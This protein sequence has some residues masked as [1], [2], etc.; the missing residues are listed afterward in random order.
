ME[1]VLNCAFGRDGA[2]MTF[3][4]GHRASIVGDTRRCPPSV[5]FEAAAS[6]AN[7]CHLPIFMSL[8]WR[9]PDFCQSRWH[10][11]V[12]RTSEVEVTYVQDTGNP[13]AT[14]I[15]AVDPRQVVQGRPTCPVRSPRSRSDTHTLGGWRAG[16][17][18]IRLS[19]NCSMSSG[20]VS[21]GRFCSR[22]SCSGTPLGSSSTAR[23]HDSRT[24]AIWCMSSKRRNGPPL[25][26]CTPRSHID[27][28]SGL[29]RK[30]PGCVQRCPQ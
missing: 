1:S 7:P 17:C 9:F 5:C 29:L 13:V 11:I 28:V 3:L 19:G 22:G 4:V 16:W 10:W 12:P 14:S 24:S 25:R 23:A 6:S 18:S 15:A 8:A 30:E 2:G 20:K 26:T 21:T 27:V